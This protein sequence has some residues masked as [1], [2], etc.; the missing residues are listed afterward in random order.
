LQALSESQSVFGVLASEKIRLGL[1]QSTR[2]LAGMI[3]NESYQAILLLYRNKIRTTG[4]S[5]KRGD[6]IT[7]Y[8]RLS[9]SR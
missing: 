4:Q 2:Q 9:N 8:A 6:T 3:M 5:G 1:P 7:V